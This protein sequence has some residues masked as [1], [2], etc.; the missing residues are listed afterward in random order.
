MSVLEKNT[1]E[2]LY[3]GIKIFCSQYSSNIFM[4]LSHT[5]SNSLKTRMVPYPLTKLLYDLLQLLWQGPPHSFSQIVPKWVL[6][7]FIHTRI[8]FSN[9]NNFSAVNAVS[10]CLTKE[11]HSLVSTT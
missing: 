2:S 7:R 5:R 1:F 8:L 4:Y 11:H 9:C 3:R 6:Q 10:C